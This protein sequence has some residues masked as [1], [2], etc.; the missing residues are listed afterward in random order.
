M[1][2]V[3]I[4]S[5]LYKSTPIVR[6]LR[7][8]C[9]DGDKR[10]GWQLLAAHQHSSSRRMLDEPT[11]IKQ[12]AMAPDCSGGSSWAPR[13][14]SHGVSVLARGP[15]FAIPA[16]HSSRLGPPGAARNSDL[17]PA[18]EMSSVSSTT[19]TSHIASSVID[20]GCEPPFQVNPLLPELGWIAHA[21]K[22]HRLIHS[23]FLHNGPWTV[24]SVMCS[25]HVG[26]GTR[27]PPLT[28]I[29]PPWEHRSVTRREIREIRI[30]PRLRHCKFCPCEAQQQDRSPVSLKILVTPVSCYRVLKHVA[31][32]SPL[33][34]RTA[35]H[36]TRPACM[37]VCIIDK[38][39]SPT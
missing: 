13:S 18:R 26:F 9:R 35:S 36:T 17:R 5:S 1:G 32:G 14:A 8:E 10:I 12:S 27:A 38:A 2:S 23:D 22:F 4:V 31:A 6:N 3:A 20:P 21:R 33:T 28:Q 37:Y 11:R 29:H 15:L 25:T 24:L 19:R 30:P 7:L 39:A 16:R 34:C